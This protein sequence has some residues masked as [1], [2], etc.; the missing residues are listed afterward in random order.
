VEQLK[1][2]NHVILFYDSAEAKRN[3]LFNYLKI[4]L[5]NGEAGVFVA[6]DESPEEIRRA[7]KK[8]GIKLK[9][10]EKREPYAFLATMRFT[11]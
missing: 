3:V 9:E 8:F 10:Y 5:E 2:T 11:L 7:I 1:P 4:E 6:G